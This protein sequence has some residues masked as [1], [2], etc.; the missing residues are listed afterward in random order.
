MHNRHNIHETKEKKS[1]DFSGLF[2]FSLTFHLP[3]F[4]YLQLSIISINFNY[5]VQNNWQI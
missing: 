3:S 4:N 1:H 5:P 2:A